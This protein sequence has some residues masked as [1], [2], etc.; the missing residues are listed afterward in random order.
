MVSDE[1]DNVDKGILYLLQQNARTSTTAD[2]SESIGVSSSTVGNRI[3]KLE[4]R[5]VITG[6]Y[7]TINYE[8]TGLNHHF[9]LDAT[10]PLEVQ[11]EIVDEV[12]HVSGV[13]TVHEML[14][15][16]R[17]VLIEL[18]G[19]N[20]EEVKQALIELNS[21]GVDIGRTTLMKQTR[22]QPYNHFGKKYTS[23]DDTG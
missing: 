2:I 8:K 10:V 1:L 6:Y 23:E 13:V 5:G 16:D 17:N 3:N 4:E 11:G 20:R 19:R 21:I 22:T 18:V 14:T 9:L 7:P 15:N 12:M